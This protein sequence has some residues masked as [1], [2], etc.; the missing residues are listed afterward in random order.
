MDYTIEQLKEA[1]AYYY[2]RS[3]NGFCFDCKVKNEKC[4]KFRKIFIA[5]A[6]EQE[7]DENNTYSI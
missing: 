1:M 6:E 7:R 2:R 3:E 4:I 5:V